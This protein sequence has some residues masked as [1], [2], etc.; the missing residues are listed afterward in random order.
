L[1]FTN[2]ILLSA[3]LAAADPM[4]APPEDSA[5]VPRSLPADSVAKASDSVP[6]IPDTLEASTGTPTKPS[7]APVVADSTVAAQIVDTGKGPALLKNT[8]ASGAVVVRGKRR[9]LDRM[10]T[11]TNAIQPT[12]VVTA[13]AIQR[14]NADDIAQAVSNEPGVDVLTAC[15]SCGFKQIQINGLG[16][17]HT[18]VLVDGLPLYSTVTGF[19][20]VDAL[21][22]AGL[23]G[24]D[25]SRGPGAS[26]LAPGAIGGAIDIRLQNPR[27]PSFTSDV[28]AGNDDWR[29][30]TFSATTRTDDGNLGLVAAG[31][32]FRQG[33]WD[34][35]DNGLTESPSLEDESGLVKLDGSLGQ[36]W[37]WNARVIQSH[38]EVFGGP[39]T[40]DFT[41]VMSTAPNELRF[42]NDDVRDDYTGTASSIVEWVAT[43][44]TESAGSL[45][46][47]SP[48]L[49]LWQLRA[50]WAGQSQT[51]EYEDAAD[52]H[53]ADNTFVADLRWE[54]T[55][56]PHTVT[57][58]TDG[59]YEYMRSK[60]QK[61]FVQDSITPDSFNSLMGGLYAQDVWNFGR[62][63]DLSVA[64]RADD[65][66]VDWI[67]KPGGPQIDDWLVSPRA[68]FRWEFVEG[69]TGRLSAGRG[70]HAPE[71]FF[72]TDH[73]ILNNGFDIEV[74]DLE[75]AWGG[76]GVLSL[77]RPKWDLSG[78]VYGTLLSN[79]AYVD[80]RG[81]I[82]V[83]RND[84]ATLPF[85]S[86]DGEGAILPFPWLKLGAGVEHQEVPDRYK[87]I[88]PV[89]AVET[90][91]TG[92]FDLQFG[93]LDWSGDVVWTA[94]RDLAPYGYGTQ[95]NGYDPATGTAFDPKLDHAPAFVVFDT[96]LD[97]KLRKEITLYVGAEN[98][99][100]YTQTVSGGD[101][102]QYFDAQGNY[103]TSHIWGPLRGR[104]MYAG[105]RWDS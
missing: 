57:L 33:Q 101:P 23:A 59:T 49:G 71:T 89:A 14:K 60:S 13:E 85:L 61:Y 64:V 68:N 41:A 84:P 70:W 12:Q 62:E 37:Y 74:H 34:A 31:H 65:A 79:L 95:Y 58:G 4:A 67:D 42:R 36:G 27:G 43:D 10:G 99:F 44:R 81:P 75:K 87:A 96:K 55:A 38:S 40:D 51:S 73:N 93:P 1:N 21:T 29:R 35:D 82:P 56:G 5:M 86:L 46:W 32:F 90:D 47:D 30:L 24:I 39:V 94:P 17:E 80:E 25:I 103:G 63:R 50:G 105:V 20:G 7:T 16:A 22:T 6:G 72:E 54:G 92:R 45:S 97:W 18:T 3:A 98:L 77:E 52:Y 28:A 76:G 11:L 8:S 91:V 102:P 104:Q 83:L 66:S 9:D 100:N 69:L 2:L 88:E 78:S 26:L 15:S 53:D 19:Y 48:G